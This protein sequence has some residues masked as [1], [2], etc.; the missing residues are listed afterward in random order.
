MA[1]FF[2][3]GG[4]FQL[5]GSLVITLPGWGWQMLDGLITFA[6]G[7]LVLIQWPASGLWV[8]GLFVGIDL[9]LYGRVWIALA[10]DLRTM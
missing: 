2:M 5:V 10:L 8:I 7:I 6:L 3:I 1:M 4:L 9:I